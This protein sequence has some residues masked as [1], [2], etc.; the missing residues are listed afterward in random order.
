[1]F[2]EKAMT[3]FNTLSEVLLYGA[4]HHAGATAF[5]QIGPGYAIDLKYSDIPVLS[6][7]FAGN[8]YTA[9]LRANDALLLWSDNSA[10]SMLAA[11]GAWRLGAHV[12]FPQST[13]SAREVS[14]LVKKYRPSL[15][16]S[17]QKQFLL[18]EDKIVSKKLINLD[19]FKMNTASDA[20]PQLPAQSADTIA[21]IFAGK[22]TETI[23]HRQ[24]ISNIFTLAKTL[25]TSRSSCVLPLSSWQNPAGF[26][27][28]S[29]ALYKGM[30]TIHS[31]RQDALNLLQIMQTEHPD[32]LLDDGIH[33]HD[34]WQAL[35]TQITQ[36]PLSDKLVV[37][38]AQQ[39]S[40]ADPRLRRALLRTVHQRLGSESPLW[41]LTES[42]Q[43]NV[44]P[45]L[46]GL[47][48]T[49][50][51]IQGSKL[52]LSTDIIAGPMVETKAADTICV[53][54]PLSEQ[55]SRLLQEVMEPEILWGISPSGSYSLTPQTKLSD[56]SLDAFSWLELQH[57]LE[58]ELNKF[59]PYLRLTE[60]RSWEDLICLVKCPTSTEW[61]AD[62]RSWPHIQL[63]PAGPQSHLSRTLL[64][65][66]L[67]CG[68]RLY[69]NFRTE[70]ADRL[71]IDP[72][73]IVACANYHSF[74]AL[75]LLS[76][77]PLS[78]LHQVHE[79]WPFESGQRLGGKA[80]TPLF[81][82][83]PWDF[84]RNFPKALQQAQELLQQGQII[85]TYAGHNQEQIPTELQLSAA[86]LAVKS[87]CPI[88]PAYISG[89]NNVLPDAAM[90]PQ[91]QQLA[92]H[93]ALPLYPPPQQCS[94]KAARQLD[95][96]L[97]QAHAQLQP[98][99][100]HQP[101]ESNRH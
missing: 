89:A 34:L 17:A 44:V 98:T 53:S 71:V 95:K 32:I 19:Q 26:Y 66:G 81:T 29:A 63:P 43:L 30:T 40:G 33:Y 87:G 21:C 69:N 9:G 62:T 91:P 28:V 38:L 55:L 37:S 70:G 101:Q 57:R 39:L 12:V 25:S 2:V 31:R 76:T 50:Q 3:K 74:N 80:H 56:L 86:Y 42:A 18:L 7:Q 94:L 22:T 99:A 96:L 77:F 100:D 92:A 15:V 90:L 16:L 8:L 59:I 52:S 4:A 41:L 36:L 88:I 11:L 23:S 6:Y 27:F 68:L 5:R 97:K 20:Y 84:R 60:C 85:I 46:R 51:Q 58:I 61:L 47:G 13:A 93:F 10:E 64:S 49:L 14:L 67:H 78:V 48:I 83:L 82:T 79:L 24:A 35:E 54:D 1:M 75:A 73:Y 45:Q 72:P 65:M